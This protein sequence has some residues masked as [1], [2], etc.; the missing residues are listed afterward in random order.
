MDEARKGTYQR[1]VDRLVDGIVLFDLDARCVF[2]NEAATGILGRPREELVGGSVWEAVPGRVATA[3]RDVF[4]RVARGERVALVRSH[5]ARGRWFEVVAIPTDEEAM[6]CFRDV[7]DRLQAEAARP[8]SEQRFRLLIDRVTEYAIF[9]LDL[10]GRVVSWNQGA[11]RI[12]GYSVE[13]VLGRHFSIFYPTEDVAADRPL[14]TLEAATV[15]GHHEE[16]G[17]RLRKD[18]S[19]FLANVVVTALFDD[20]GAPHGFAKIVR[21]ITDRVRSEQALRESRERLQLALDAAEVGMSDYYPPTGQMIWDARQKEMWGLPPDVEVG[22]EQFVAGIHP[23]DRARVLEIAR[24]TYHSGRS[25]TVSLEFRTIGLRDRVERWLSARWMVTVDDGGRTQRMTGAVRDVTDRHRVDEIR[26]RMPG[27]FAHDLRSPLAAIRAS[28][29]LLLRPG[30][31]PAEAER[32]TRTILRSADRISRMIRQLMDFTR[33]RLGGGLPLVRERVD[34][35]ELC[36]DAC[37]ESGDATAACDIRLDVQG[38]CSGRW[39]RVHLGRVISNLLGNALQHGGPQ[40]S[41]DVVV[42]GEG[43]QVTVCIHNEGLP[44][45]PETLRG[46][47]E[48]FQRG[49]RVRRDAASSSLGLGLYIAKEIVAAHG[50]E[51]DVAST[52]HDGT[53]FRFSLPREPGADTAAGAPAPA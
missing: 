4:E 41:V 9:M 12:K 14:R 26:D 28:A 34:L 52:A 24:R 17:W 2:V 46:L 36:Q 31:L 5:F 22:Y 8:Q 3:L 27:I 11:K 21:D 33:T 32:P 6:L 1:I 19:R 7:T 29:E 23:A 47:F 10:E 51:I 38:D 53:T 42:R 49:P 18:G 20:L 43:P 44:I 35:A 37:T 40:R 13:E 16:D 30:S 50:G 48:P 39:D 45:P 25:R 15:Y